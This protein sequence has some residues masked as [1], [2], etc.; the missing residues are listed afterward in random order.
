M[1]LARWYSSRCDCSKAVLSISQPNFNFIYTC[2]QW[3]WFC[4]LLEF[5]IHFFHIVIV[6]W[7][8]ILIEQHKGANECL[9]T[10]HVLEHFLKKIDWQS[11]WTTSLSRCFVNE[12]NKKITVNIGLPNIYIF[13]PYIGFREQPRKF[14]Q[15]SILVQINQ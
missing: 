2:L 3:H 9:N 15:Q 13:W 8:S 4:F 5:L 12:E 1:R 7:F 14:S 6:E 10:I 11:Q